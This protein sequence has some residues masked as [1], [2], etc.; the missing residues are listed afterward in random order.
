MIDMS[1][2]G[3]GGESDVGEHGVMN[4]DVYSEYWCFKCKS[5]QDKV[6]SSAGTDVV[7]KALRALKGWKQPGD[8]DEK[9][10]DI[11]LGEDGIRED[12][13]FKFSSRE[14]VESGNGNSTEV[15]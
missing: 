6:R 15:R 11:N 2:L 9:S 5:R 4:G 1:C 3:C 14:V 7:G 10:G 12:N 13:E 8:M